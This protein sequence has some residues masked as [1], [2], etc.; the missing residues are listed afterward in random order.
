MKTMD[1][2][3][4]AADLESEITQSP[5]KVVVARDITVTPLN[6]TCGCVNMTCP[7][8]V[9]PP[10]KTK[11]PK[12]D[13]DE[14]GGPHCLDQN[15]D[16]IRETGNASFSSLFLASGAVG[17]AQA[18]DSETERS[19]RPHSRPPSP[20]PRASGPGTITLPRYTSQGVA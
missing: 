2:D 11:L 19:R 1:L 15:S 14:Y 6:S 13:V 12:C 3:S 10:P 4:L 18:S 8:H 20:H 9:P 5:A 16:F 17:A 7:A